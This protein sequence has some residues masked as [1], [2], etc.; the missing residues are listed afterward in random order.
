MYL[1]DD[2]LRH[3]MTDEVFSP[4]IKTYGQLTRSYQNKE[5][6]FSSKF[7]G[8]VKEQLQP[9]EEEAPAKD[10]GNDNEGS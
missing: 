3:G 9:I 1:W 8:L 5:A 2:V 10:D 6:V 4:K 7:F